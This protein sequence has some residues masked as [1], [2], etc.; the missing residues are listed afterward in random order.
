[1]FD[2]SGESN[3]LF[4]QS[5]AINKLSIISLLACSIISGQAA[6]E[7]LVETMPVPMEFTVKAPS[8]KY[9]ATFTANPNLVANAEAQ[10]IGTLQVTKVGEAN[11]NEYVCF[12]S[13]TGANYIEFTRVDDPK[14]T[15]IGDLWGMDEYISRPHKV[16]LNSTTDSPTCTNWQTNN[17]KYTIGGIDSPKVGHFTGMLYLM[18]YQK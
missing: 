1:M 17:G 14:I 18:V 16:D 2:I 11:P 13:G 15:M 6:A 7:T 9:T 3:S 5:K 12:S 10:D 8:G 4:L